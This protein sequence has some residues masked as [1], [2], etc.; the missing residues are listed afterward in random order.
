M[1][2]IPINPRTTIEKSYVFEYVGSPRTPNRLLVCYTLQKQS[3]EQKQHS[4]WTPHIC[5][6][7]DKSHSLQAS[8]TFDKI[9]K[10]LNLYLHRL[11]NTT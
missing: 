7:V 5:M 2:G 4:T 8:T 11:I 10:K 9:G 1:I 6:R 3:F